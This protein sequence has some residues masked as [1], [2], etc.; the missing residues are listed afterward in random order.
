MLLLVEDV[1]LALNAISTGAEMLRRSSSDA[2]VTAVA[3]RIRSSTRRMAKMIEQLLDVARIR[4][5]GVS[6]TMQP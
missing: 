4:A 3:E 2:K 1:A 6:L 5:G